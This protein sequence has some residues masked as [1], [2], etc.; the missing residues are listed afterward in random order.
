MFSS[1]A[2]VHIKVPLAVKQQSCA[3]KSSVPTEGE[4]NNKESWSLELLSVKQWVFISQGG[5]L[6]IHT[7]RP[8]SVLAGAN[9]NLLLSKLIKAKSHSERRIVCISNH[10]QCISYPQEFSDAPPRALPRLLHRPLFPRLVRSWRCSPLPSSSRSSPARLESPGKREQTC[11][12]T[13]YLR[14]VHILHWLR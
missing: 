9:C 12:R 4:R 8:F 7:F 3:V 1:A 2:H 14:R 10:G 6:C 5:L 13:T 11:R